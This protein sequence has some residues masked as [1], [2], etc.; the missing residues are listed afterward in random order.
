MYIFG[1]IAVAITLMKNEGF[2]LL[3]WNMVKMFFLHC[4]T[5][6]GQLEVH[7]DMITL[8]FMPVNLFSYTDTANASAVDDF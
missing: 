8:L 1:V 4:M 5:S 3:H 7:L 6:G 2:Q